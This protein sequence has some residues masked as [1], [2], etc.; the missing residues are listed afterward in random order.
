LIRKPI[1][2]AAIVAVL[3]L[4]IYFLSYHF[5]PKLGRGT[6]KSPGY[7]IPA[8]AF[9]IKDLNGQQLTLADF[10]GKV[11]LLDFWAT[12]CAPCR[13]EIPRF[14]GWQNQYRNQALQVVGISMDDDVAAVRQFYRQFQMNYPV[15][16]GNT[17]VADA[18]GG[19]LGLPVTFLIGRDGWIYAK[20]VGLADLN[21]LQGEIK[22]QLQK[23]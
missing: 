18:Y 15:A 3:A 20:H 19:I 16:M 4:G 10:R 17:Q 22:S 23:P 21:V 2:I 5:L 6:L 7:P 1:F 11:I 8:P 14:V 9:S 13:E 12:W